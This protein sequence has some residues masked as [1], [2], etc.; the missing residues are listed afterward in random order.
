[1][2]KKTSEKVYILNGKKYKSLQHLADENNV[3]HSKVVRWIKQRKDSSGNIIRIVTRTVN[4][5]GE[6]TN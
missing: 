2:H 1:M 5:Y 4:E 3:T 6:F